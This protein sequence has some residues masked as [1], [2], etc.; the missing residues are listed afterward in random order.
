MYV[1]WRNKNVLRLVFSL[2]TIWKSQVLMEMC[3]RHISWGL[4]AAGA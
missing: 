3:A 1:R 4:K 2:S